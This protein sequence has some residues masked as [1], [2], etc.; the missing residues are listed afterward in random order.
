M[1][2]GLINLLQI[3]ADFA[4]EIVILLLSSFTIVWIMLAIAQVMKKKREAS[5][6]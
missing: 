4:I 2:N 6:E 5:K 3:A 1:A